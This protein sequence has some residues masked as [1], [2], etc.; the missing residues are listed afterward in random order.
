[1]C[2]EDFS[3]TAAAV[4]PKNKRSPGRRLTLSTRGRNR[5]PPNRPCR[6]VLQSRRGSRWPRTI[7]I[8]QDASVTTAEP[9]IAVARDP[10][11]DCVADRPWDKVEDP[12]PL[13]ARKLARNAQDG[14]RFYIAVTVRH[15]R[16]GIRAIRI[17]AELLGRRT[18]LRQ[19]DW[20][21]AKIAAAITFADEA[22]AARAEDAYAVEQNQAVRGVDAARTVWINVD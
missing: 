9:T 20:N 14:F 4:L 15:E 11:I 10:V 19:L 12:S 2:V 1:L 3:S 16:E 18:S 6:F 8:R 17:Y 13:P 21:E 5:V 22:A 7:R